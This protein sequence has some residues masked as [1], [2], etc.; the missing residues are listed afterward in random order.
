[1]EGSSAMTVKFIGQPLTIPGMGD[2]DESNRIGIATVFPKA[3][4]VVTLPGVHTTQRMAFTDRINQD[5]QTQ[6]L[7]PLTSD[8]RMDF[9]LNAVDLLIDDKHILIRPDPDRMDLAFEADELLQNIIPRQHIRFLFANN[10]KVRN[11]INHRGEAWRIQP[12]PRS[13]QD[14]CQLIN[15]SRV[16]VQGKPIYYYC[17]VRGTRILTYQQFVQLGSMRIEELR[18]HLQEIATLA[19]RRN[20]MGWQELQLFMAGNGM[21][22]SDLLPDDIAK[23]SSPQLRDMH[24]RACE[25][26]AEAVPVAFQLDDVNHAQWRNRMYCTLIAQG[27]DT[28]SDEDLLGLG[29]EYFMQIRWLPGARVEGKELIFDTFSNM[30]ELVNPIVHEL[31]CNIIREY[32]DIRF[33]NIGQVERSVSQRQG[34]GDGSRREVYLV[35]FRSRESTRDELQIIRFHKWGVRERLDEGKDLTCA[36]LESEEYSDYIMDRRLACRQLGMNLVSRLWTRKIQERYYGKQGHLNGTRIWTPYVQRDYISGVATDK[37]LPAKLRDS[38]FVRSL[39]QM[40]GKAAASNLIVGRGTFE[41]KVIFDDGDEVLVSNPAGQ[42]TD[43]VIADPTGA[44]MNFENE[45]ARDAPAY[46]APINRRKDRL[47]NSDVFLEIYLHSFVA[48]FEQIQNA[49]R[50]HRVAFDSLFSHRRRDPAGNLAHRWAMVLKRLDNANPNKLSKIIRD[51]VK[52]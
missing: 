47:T 12:L 20:A 39:A 45:L 4:V 16:A 22:V 14:M 3:G 34:P 18:Q 32:D 38:E 41:H 10:D 7:E 2:Q 1:M 27:D 35:H 40:L 46:A 13:M 29:N 19:S 8:E 31:I 44:F 25:R 17:G 28:L 49:Y 43:M 36:M 30:G 26:L 42:V 52:Y 48:R 21:H 50:R 51:H 33:L 24:A 9:W 6:G 37:V 23:Y 11:A 5:R 15:R